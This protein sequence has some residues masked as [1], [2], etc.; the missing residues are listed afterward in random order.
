MASLEIILERSAKQ[1]SQSE[2]EVFAAEKNGYYVEML[3]DMKPSDVSD[4]C[5]FTLRA[6]REKGIKIAI[7][8]SSKN[9]RLILRQVGLTEYFDAISDGNCITRSKPDPEIFLKAAEMLGLHPEECLIVEDAYSGIDAG[10]AGGFVTVA[11][12][13]ACNYDKADH[14]IKK[15]SDLMRLPDLCDKT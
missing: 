3:K 2:K 7:G 8:S 15:L 1:Y 13:Q 12:G 10:I 9:A 14:T 4:D 5:I 6:L 11:I